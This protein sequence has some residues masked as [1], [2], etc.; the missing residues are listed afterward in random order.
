MTRKKNIRSANG[1]D[2]KLGK[3]VRLRR[4]EQGM[5]QAEL[6]AA[7]G[8]SFQQ[9]QK[10]EKGINRIGAMRLQEIAKA[11]HTPSSFFYES[12]GKHDSEVESLMFVD[13]AYTL[14]LLRAYN[15]L[16]AKRPVFARSFVHLIEAARTNE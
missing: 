14:R 6:G 4:V 2:A 10:Y 11:L 12:R 16:F 3:L 13:S 7:L 5:S 8:V 15:E 1:E 9:V